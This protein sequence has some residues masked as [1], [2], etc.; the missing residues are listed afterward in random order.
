MIKKPDQ[1]LTFNFRITSTNHPA[2]PKAQVRRLSKLGL[3]S[4]KLSK[5]GAKLQKTTFL[6]PYLWKKS[7]RLNLKKQRSKTLRLILS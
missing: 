2:L 3:H 7:D 6:T 4:V 1:D 5:L